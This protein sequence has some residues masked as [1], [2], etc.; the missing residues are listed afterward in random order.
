[1]AFWKLHSYI[2]I[3]VAWCW[4]VR[5]VLGSRICAHNTLFAHWK[6]WHPRDA[7]HS[8]RQGLS[9]PHHSC[10]FYSISKVTKTFNAKTESSPMESEN[11]AAP[12]SGVFSHFSMVLNLNKSKVGARQVLLSHPWCLKERPVRK[13]CARY[14]HFSEMHRSTFM[15]IRLMNMKYHFI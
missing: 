12:G 5:G 13:K 6:N 7:C 4:P 9:E 3:Q 11:K 8:P 15:F 2:A 10:L 1:M 14:Q